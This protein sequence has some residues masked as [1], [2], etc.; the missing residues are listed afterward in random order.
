MK[1]D[2]LQLCHR[3]K[4]KDHYLH[5][6]ASVLLPLRKT[7]ILKYNLLLKACV[8]FLYSHCTRVRLKLKTLSFYVLLK[9]KCKTRSSLW[10]EFLVVGGLCQLWTQSRIISYVLIKRSLKHIFERQENHV[11][12]VSFYR[13]SGNSVDHTYNIFL[14]FFHPLPQVHRKIQ[15]NERGGTP[16]IV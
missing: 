5:N 3:L 12:S 4:R 8:S 16:T 6:K 2:V 7:R 9:L 14:V 1:L 13:A 10:L 11:S 15:C